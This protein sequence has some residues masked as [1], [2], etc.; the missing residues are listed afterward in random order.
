[1]KSFEEQIEESM[2]FASGTFMKLNELR[3]LYYGRRDLYVSFTNDADLD[4]KNNGMPNGLLGYA[5]NDVVGRR[6]S[7]NNFYGWV[8]RYSPTADSIIFDVRQ[9]TKDDLRHDIE[10][11]QDK[12][13]GFDIN[14]IVNNVLT[15]LS[16]THPFRKMYKITEEIATSVSSDYT[17]KWREILFKDLGYGMI[18][19]PTQSGWL[20]GRKEPVNLILNYAKRMDLDILE[21]Q[22]YRTDPRQRVRDQVFRKV[23]RFSTKRNRISKKKKS[24]NGK[25]ETVSFSDMIDALKGYFQ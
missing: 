12:D 9:Y 6:K 16:I 5:V 23:K 4:T 7:S 2:G 10:I 25:D 3:N 11:L 13:Y 19:D 20:T 17:E 14:D 24:L 21:I 15:S 18:S 8:Y 22:K 1:M